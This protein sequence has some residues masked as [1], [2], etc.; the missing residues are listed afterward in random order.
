MDFTGQFRL[1]EDSLN[2]NVFQTPVKDAIQG[3]K[4]QK[5]IYEL[6]QLI[7]ILTRTYFGAYIIIWWQ[8]YLFQILKALV[9]LKQILIKNCLFRMNLLKSAKSNL[10]LQN[11]QKNGVSNILVIELKKNYKIKQL[12]IKKYA[13]SQQKK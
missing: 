13:K 12:D 3:K 4:I 10:I 6:I 1:D 2:F 8:Y 5:Q 7:H 9:I 11:K